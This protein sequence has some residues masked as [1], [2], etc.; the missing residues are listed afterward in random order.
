M[1]SGSYRHFHKRPVSLYMVERIG[2][3]Q[4]LIKKSLC[5]VSIGGDTPTVISQVFKSG[6]ICATSN[7]WVMRVHLIKLNERL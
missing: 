1:A 5:I 7:R 4:A 6:A 3:S 2:D